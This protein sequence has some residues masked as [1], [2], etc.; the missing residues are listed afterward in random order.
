MT[1]CANCDL[2]FEK[3][4]DRRGYFRYSIENALPNSGQVARDALNKFTGNSVTPVAKKSGKFLCPSCW[5]SLSDSV[6]YQNS[7]N[8]F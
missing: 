4:G 2:P 7:L 8:E 1:N 3:M 5:A 6:R